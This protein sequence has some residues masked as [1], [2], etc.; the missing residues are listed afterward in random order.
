MFRFK[1]NA[2]LM[3]CMEQC[4][5]HAYSGWTGVEDTQSTKATVEGGKE[6][7]LKYLDFKKQ[8]EMDEAK[9]LILKTVAGDLLNRIMDNPEIKKL[10]IEMTEESSKKTK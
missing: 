8:I 1:D 10:F 4:G 7:I 2:R 3:P 6:L 9:L 5:P